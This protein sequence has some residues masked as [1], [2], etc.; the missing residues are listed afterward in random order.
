MGVT[1]RPR[2]NKI[3]I[4]YIRFKF[5]DLEFF[6]F[7][8]N[9]DDRSE[10]SEGAGGWLDQVRVVGFG[11][12]LSFSIVVDEL[13]L[14]D[15]IAEGLGLKAGAVAA[16]A[17]GSD[18][19][20]LWDKRIGF[21]LIAILFGP[22]SELVVCDAGADFDQMPFWATATFFAALSTIHSDFSDFSN[23]VEMFDI[24]GF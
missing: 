21:Y 9:K 22:Y 18:D 4:I 13:E 7:E 1:F 2:N 19:S 24:F 5:H 20:G 8:C 11:D 12:G 17:D 10:Q 3:F 14:I 15:V 6:H 23:L 16:G